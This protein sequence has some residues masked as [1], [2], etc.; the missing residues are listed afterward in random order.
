MRIRR[1]TLAL[2]AA[3]AVAASLLVAAPAT[4]ANPSVSGTV[5]VVGA[6]PDA[7]AG[8]RVDV[9]YRPDD[10]EFGPGA[11]T[12]PTGYTAA[13]GTYSL[14]TELSAGLQISLRFSGSLGAVPLATVWNG[15]ALMFDQAAVITLSPTGTSGVDISMEFAGAIEGTVA[16]WD[17]SSVDDVH[18]RY[19]RVEEGTGRLVQRGV[20][21]VVGGAYLLDD[22]PSGAYVVRFSERPDVTEELNPLYWTHDGGAR[23]L[24]DADPVVVEPGE[25]TAVAGVV[26]PTRSFDVERISGADRYAT[27]VEITQTVVPGPGTVSVPVVYLASG[28]SFPDALAAGPAASHLGGVVL[29]TARDSLP[30]IVA[31]ELDR[32]NPDR[33]VI[34]G[35]TSAISA[36]VEAAVTAFVDVSSDVVRING[37]DRYATAR[38]LVADAFEGDTADDVVIAT[39]RD[40]PD[41]L[42]AGSL[43]GRLDG[44]VLLIDGLDPASPYAL[45]DLVVDLETVNVVIAGGS[46][47]IPTTTARI[48]PTFGS[49]DRPIALVFVGGD[50][51]YGTAVNLGDV[52]E[53]NHDV[54]VLTTGS[55]FVDAL[56]GGVL[57]ASLDAAMYLTRSSCVPQ[58]TLNALALNDVQRIILLGGTTALGPGVESL[59]P[60]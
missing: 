2:F 31:T 4:A 34:A 53:S 58:E 1:I 10:G 43:A 21:A 29:L 9:I 56:A 49:T 19:F 54:A 50:N 11:Y 41:A 51:R 3:T 13:D 52:G 47:V 40:F 30:A 60:C 26:L 15:G 22:L 28:E 16:A 42:G 37:A 39:G 14:E 12:G 48:F 36:A 55:G 35:G 33:I 45:E 44:A 24:D 27:A 25:T 8:I 20:V 38:L 23:Y 32:L 57:A 18:V 6:A 59:T 17:S 7:L 46:G 5:T